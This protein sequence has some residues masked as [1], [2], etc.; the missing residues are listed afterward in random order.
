MKFTNLLPV[1]PLLYS[2]LVLLA[3]G[4]DADSS[5]GTGDTAGRGSSATGGANTGG[6]GGSGSSSGGDLDDGG[7]SGG[8]GTERKQVGDP[9][10][11]HAQCPAFRGLKGYCFTD[12][13][14]G[15]CA[16]EQC[17]GDLVCPLDSRCVDVD[18]VQFCLRFCFTD[19]A[20]RDG[21]RCDT[22]EQACVPA[23]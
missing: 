4:D 7:D 10:T 12:W 6:S 2:S 23:D 18:G 22:G 8:G 17:D 15:S 16:I 5:A 3:C 19:T 13:P 1:L 20:C 14:G 9:C 11:D 21:Y